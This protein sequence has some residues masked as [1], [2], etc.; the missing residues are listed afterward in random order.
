MVVVVVC[1]LWEQV[2]LPL[3][4]MAG[5]C[6][7]FRFVGGNCLAANS[8]VSLC[9]TPN[10]CSCVSVCACVNETAIAGCSSAPICLSLSLSLSVALALSLSVHRSIGPLLSTHRTQE[11]KSGQKRDHDEN[12]V[13][14]YKSS[15]SM[16]SV[17]GKTSPANLPFTTSLGLH[18][19][20][21]PEF[22]V[23]LYYGWQIL[24]NVNAWLALVGIGEVPERAELWSWL[25]SDGWRVPLGES[26]W[27]SVHRESFVTPGLAHLHHLYL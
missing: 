16:T 22:L 1:V 19:R 23:S 5:L 8:S 4:I 21:L 7:P 27:P 10:V 26:C 13:S 6:Y 2:F 11:R 3:T 15:R 12:G 14:C 24:I 25:C 18:A 20:S 17:I 9:P